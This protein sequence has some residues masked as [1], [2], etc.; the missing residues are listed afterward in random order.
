MSFGPAKPYNVKAHQSKLR[1]VYGPSKKKGDSGSSG[2]KGKGSSGKGGKGCAAAAGD[3]AD[4]SSSSDAAILDE[5]GELLRVISA[6]QQ[7]LHEE[8]ERA[9]EAAA[10]A[11]L[12]RR[13]LL[14]KMPEAVLIE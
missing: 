1:D 13:L 7:L 4:A 8:T 6:L 11:R 2:N 5:S 10:E 9:E 12:R 3:E 14:A